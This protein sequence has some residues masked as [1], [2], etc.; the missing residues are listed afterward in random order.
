LLTATIRGVMM[1][2]E[3]TNGI[4]LLLDLSLQIHD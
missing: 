1:L 2:V 4:N 3:G